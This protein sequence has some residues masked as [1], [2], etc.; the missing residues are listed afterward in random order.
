MLHLSRDPELRIFRAIHHQLRISLLRLRVPVSGFQ[1]QLSSLCKVMCAKQTCNSNSSGVIGSA[2]ALCTFAS[3]RVKLRETAVVVNGELECGICS[4]A[5][6]ERRGFS[7]YF[8]A[9]LTHQTAALGISVTWDLH[10]LNGY[11]N[12]KIN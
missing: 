2:L 7:C 10:Q 8:F 6:C 5:I 1:S 12:N 9:R 4:R 3:P 11:R